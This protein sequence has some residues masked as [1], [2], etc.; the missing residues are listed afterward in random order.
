MSGI[1]LNPRMVVMI[2]RLM[3]VFDINELSLIKNALSDKEFDI[4]CMRSGSG[5]Y[6]GKLTLKQI[7]ELYK[8]TSVRISHIESRAKRK[9][10]QF[11]GPSRHILYD[12]FL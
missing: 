5:K 3:R 12:S 8:V 4:I 7:G 6:P 10:R 9:C 11:F 1:L 2:D